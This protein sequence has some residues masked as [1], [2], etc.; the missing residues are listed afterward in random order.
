MISIHEKTRPKVDVDLGETG[1]KQSLKK[2]LQHS[3]QTMRDSYA[4]ASPYLEKLHFGVLNEDIDEQGKL[5]QF[6]QYNFKSRL[7]CNSEMLET[8]EQ[9][10]LQD[11]SYS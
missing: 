5:Y 7:R 10:H 9:Q 4:E 11:N 1:K 3:S 2:L 8:F 6:T